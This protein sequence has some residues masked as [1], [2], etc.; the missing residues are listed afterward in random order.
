MLSLEC[1][2]VEDSFQVWTFLLVKEIKST[3][4]SR[5]H[6]VEQKIHRGQIISQK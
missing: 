1:T 2:G 3:A 6:R 4:T 5:Q